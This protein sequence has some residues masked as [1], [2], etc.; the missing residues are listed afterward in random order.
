MGQHLL[1]VSRPVRRRLPSTRIAVAAAFVAAAIAGAATPAALHMFATPVYDT[2]ATA[3]PRLPDI[4]DAALREFGVRLDVPTGHG[5]AR[6]TAERARDVALPLGEGP[7]SDGWSIAGSPVLVF[8][9]Y[10]ATA[11]SASRTCLCWA[12]ELNSADGIPCDGA[13][14]AATTGVCDNHRLV[15]LIDASSGGRWLSF[16]GHGLG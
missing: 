1:D 5:A 4:S 6:I 10:G 13:T 16:S 3:A 15:E 9:E 7:Q 11:S 14:G 2:S 12:V 8:A